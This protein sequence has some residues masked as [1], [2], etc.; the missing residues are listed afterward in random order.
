MF[1]SKLIL[2]CLIAHEI[3]AQTLSF[4][5]PT[6]SLSL[7]FA[8][9]HKRNNP[10]LSTPSPSTDNEESVV[11][12]QRKHN[13]FQWTNP[14]SQQTHSINYKVEGNKSDPPI[15]LVHGF[16]ANLNH[17]RY[18]FPALVNAGH[19]VYAVD[20]LGFGG[21][22]KP[23]EE[24]YSIELWVD[25]LSTFIQE[26]SVENHNGEETKWVV[27]GNSIG[28][29]CS[30]GVAAKLQEQIRGITLFN[31]S[32]GM[33]SFRYEDVPFLL[34]PILFFVQ[35]VALSPDGYGGK[36]F[37]NFKTRE[38]VENI[39]RSQVYVDTSNVNEE[40]L[41]ILL[42]PSDDDGAKEVFLKVFGGNPG[43][44]PKSI[45]SEID[46]NLP[47]LAL[48]GSNDPWTP[49]DTLGKSL[50]EFAI[51]GGYSFDLRVLDGSSH[52][53]HDEV[54]E[55]VHDEMIPWLHNL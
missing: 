54:P 20:L 15:L 33:S 36:F 6:S 14:A 24:E 27:A 37:E 42:G 22:D 44:T 3:F 23:K 18:N 52:C 38:N 43:P 45:L 32:G 55:K 34:R 30:L 39:L 21:S 47:I 46:V 50:N 49:V 7:P 41:E 4:T 11:R 12:V 19:C 1:A 35:K 2:A 51:A 53:L 17:F 8:L 28:G 13:T 5:V 10:L 9:K 16:G 25:L 26:K 29:L 48:W 31:T 40:L